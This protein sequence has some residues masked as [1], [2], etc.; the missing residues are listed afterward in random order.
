MVIISAVLLKARVRLFAQRLLHQQNGFFLMFFLRPICRR[1]LVARFSRL[2]MGIWNIMPK[3]FLCDRSPLPGKCSSQC[4]CRDS[5][6]ACHGWKKWEPTAPL[7]KFG[8][9]SVEQATSP[10]GFK[11]GLRGL[12]LRA[13]YYFS[14]LARLREVSG[15]GLARKQLK[16]QIV[17]PSLASTWMPVNQFFDQT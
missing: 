8:G 17:P 1:Q 5:M 14:T 4:S 11:A 3:F 2:C 9:K 12:S 7:L 10:N 13:V 6:L 16:N 15:P